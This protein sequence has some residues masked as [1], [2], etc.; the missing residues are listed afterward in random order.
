MWLSAF[1]RFTHTVF[2]VNTLG[3][4]LTRVQGKKEVLDKD[5]A[6]FE[7][8]LVLGSGDGTEVTLVGSNTLGD[9]GDVN[10]A[11]GDLRFGHFEC[12]C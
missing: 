4:S 12:L 3:R 6:L 8:G 7:L 9:L 10:A 11:V 1:V 5:G 2:L